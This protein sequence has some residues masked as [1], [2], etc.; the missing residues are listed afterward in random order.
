MISDT[1]TCNKGKL[2]IFVSKDECF[3]DDSVADERRVVLFIQAIV[4]TD[5]RIRG[6]M[7][8]KNKS[9]L[10]KKIKRGGLIPYGVIFRRINA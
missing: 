10:K 2:C 9:L 1:H 7:S 8:H 5:T 4:D 6:F 3:R